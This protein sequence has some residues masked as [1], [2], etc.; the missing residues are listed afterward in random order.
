MVSIAL[1]SDRRPWPPFRSCWYFGCPPRPAALHGPW[2]LQ[3]PTEA[4]LPSGPFLV[5]V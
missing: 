1:L 2:F 5:P 3:V 4:N